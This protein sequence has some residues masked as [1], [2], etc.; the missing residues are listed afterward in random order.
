MRWLG[1]LPAAVLLLTACGEPR[2]SHDPLVFSGQVSGVFRPGPPSNCGVGQTAVTGPYGSGTTD[3]ADL[4]VSDEGSVSVNLGAARGTYSG[5]GVA[6][7]P[8]LGWDIDADL[9][10]GIGRTLHLHGHLSC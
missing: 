7:R 3:T 5:M 4:T 1:A 9:H 8:P 10:S 2:V 6:F